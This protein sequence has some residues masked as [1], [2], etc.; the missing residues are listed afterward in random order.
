V[1]SNSKSARQRER[2]IEGMFQQPT[3]A[4]AAEAAGISQTTA[5]RIRRTPEF[6]REY[7]LARQQSHGHARA[8]SQYWSNSAVSVLLRAMTDSQVPWSS[9]LRA[10]TEITNLAEKATEQDQVDERSERGCNDGHVDISALTD[11]QLILARQL[12]L[13]ATKKKKHEK[14]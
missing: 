4:K 3:L 11:E 6:E 13:A 7:R 14:A 1:V 5:W 10:A 12:A 9:R 2:L 8:R